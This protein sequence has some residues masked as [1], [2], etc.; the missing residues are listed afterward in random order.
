MSLSLLS[1]VNPLVAV[2]LARKSRVSL[3]QSVQ[4]VENASACIM[5]ADADGIIVSMNAA[6]RSMF[7]ETADDIR[8]Q[9][10]FFDP[11][12][13]VG[14]SFDAFH[15]DPAPTQ[16]PADAEGTSRGAHSHC[17]THFST[18]RNTAP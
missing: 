7:V 3:Q 14:S 2:G 9:Y 17:D 13:L 5:V 1:L 18:G 12:K 15:A 10:P 16:Y 8:Q 4:I 6:L 11:A